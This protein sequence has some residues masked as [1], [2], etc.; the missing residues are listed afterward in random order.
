V[1]LPRLATWLFLVG[2][3]FSFAR[4]PGGANVYLRTGDVAL[5]GLAV[6]AVAVLGR[7]ARRDHTVIVASGCA[8]VV[9]VAGYALAWP[10][11]RGPEPSNPSWI[12]GVAA[13][14][15]CSIAVTFARLYYDEELFLDAFWKLTFAAVGV[16]LA[17]Y[18]LN[19]LTGSGWLTHRQYGT[20]RLQGFLSEP[21]GWAPYL[22]ALV[23]LALGRRRYVAFGIALLAVI[24][25]KS[26]T[27]FLVVALS[28]T[29]YAV[30]TAKRHRALLLGLFV[31]LGV[32]AF[33]WL[34]HVPVESELSSGI[35]DQ[36]VGRLA[37]GIENITS[38]G[39]VGRNDRYE[40]TRAVFTTLTEHGWLAT[41]IGPGSEGFIQQET[42]RVPNSLAAYAL[43]SFG[44]PGLV[45]LCAAI[46]VAVRR[47]RTSTSL[48]LFLPFFVAAFINS[49][50]GWESYKFVVVAIVAALSLG[51]LRVL[52]RSGCLAQGRF[53]TRAQ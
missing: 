44:V 3:L 5:L 49:A 28:V 25:T 53:T 37:G 9:L 26:P 22:A 48:R 45:M 35:Y 46:C 18:G 7:A 8:G 23:L 16:G 41:G 4:L 17:A 2:A 42:G 32:L 12:L 30:I 33:T 14:A 27:V 13:V 50:G 15:Y 43:S 29:S 19:A 47:L 11:M 6:L 51:P 39:T 24:L 38:G 1:T 10:L 21:S 40:I 52:S 20:P 36:I 31:G 34:P